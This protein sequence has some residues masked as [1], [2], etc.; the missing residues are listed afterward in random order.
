[1]TIETADEKLRK[2]DCLKFPVPNSRIEE[3]I[4]SALSHGCRK[5]DLFF[6]VGIPH[7]TYEN[8]H[9]DRPLLREPHPAVQ[10]RPRLQ[11]FV[12]PMGPFLDPGCGAFEDPKYGYRHFYRTLEEHRRALLH[13]TWKSILSYETD[14]MSR[15][16]IMTPSY[17]VASEA[18]RTEVQARADR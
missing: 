17:E 16:E 6:M 10:R 15:N 2:L 3:T 4:S 5:L 1:M 18:E 14:A 9:G 13:P 7:Q 8:A 11:F 12:S